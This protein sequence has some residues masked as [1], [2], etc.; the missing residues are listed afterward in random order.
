MADLTIC[1]GC[2]SCLSCD[3][4]QTVCPQ[5]CETFRLHLGEF[6]FSISPTSN[7]SMCPNSGQFNSSVWNE[8]YTY[9]NDGYKIGSVVNSGKTLTSTG[10]FSPFTAAEFNNV[11]SEIGVSTVSPNSLIKGTYFQSLETAVGG[12]QVDPTACDNECNVFCMKCNSSNCDTTT[13]CCRCDTCQA[14]DDGLCQGSCDAR[15]TTC[16]TQNEL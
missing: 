5:S 6:S 11:A 7:N 8:I 4:S 9:I 14:C 3:K 2:D 10:G 15:Q 13:Y 16:G 1:S 12:M